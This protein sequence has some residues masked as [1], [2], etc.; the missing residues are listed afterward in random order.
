[1][2]DTGELLCGSATLDGEYGLSGLSMGVPMRLGKGGI[3]EIVELELTA[4][5]QAAV[6]RRW[7]N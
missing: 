2:K 3:Q 5:E 1:M 4:D 6:D 7:N